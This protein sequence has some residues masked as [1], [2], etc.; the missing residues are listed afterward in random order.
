[1]STH[2]LMSICVSIA[3]SVA[4]LL[5]EQFFGREDA[6]RVLGINVVGDEIKVFDKRSEEYIV[7]MIVKSNI[8]SVRIVSEE[9]GELSLS[10]SPEYIVLVDPVDGSANFAA[11]IPYAAVSIA[12]ARAS[13]TATLQSLLAGAVAWIGTGRVFSFATSEGVY[14]DGKKVSVPY[15]YT[16]TRIIASYINSDEAFKCVDGIRRYLG[17]ASLRCYG[18]ASLDIVLTA[19]GKYRIFVDL[20]PKLRNVDVAAALGFSR[21][22]GAHMV[23]S[24]GSNFLE[25]IP[26]WNVCRIKPLIVTHD[27]KLLQYVLA[28]CRNLRLT[29]S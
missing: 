12:V 16:K 24:D 11:G 7:D 9:L 28:L 13:R 6:S 19:L 10:E 27:F 4:K 14:V 22:L 26:I 21:E 20:K 5:E 8:G 18:A 1:M 23:T 29:D 25:L 17:R 15:D 2:N 3:R